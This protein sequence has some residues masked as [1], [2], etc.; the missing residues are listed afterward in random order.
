MYAMITP[1]NGSVLVE[2]TDPL[3]YVQTPDKQYS[4]KTSGIVVAQDESIQIDLRGK[5]IYFSEF[6]DGTK[7]DDKHALIKYEDIRGFEQD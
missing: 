2:L 5:C 6:Q 4:T 1:I 7:V 3:E